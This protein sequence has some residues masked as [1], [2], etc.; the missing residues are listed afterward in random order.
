MARHDTAGS[1]R[2]RRSKADVIDV[3]VGQDKK[4]DVLDPKA[5]PPK[6]SLEILERLRGLRA[7]VDECRGSPRSR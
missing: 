1:L 4:L 5:V 3:L 7:C 2:D 6:S